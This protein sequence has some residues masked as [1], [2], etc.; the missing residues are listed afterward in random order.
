M[1]S[2]RVT[3]MTHRGAVRAGNE[4]ALVIGSLTACGVSMPDPI[5][6]ELALSSP[7]LVAVADGMGGH[8]GGAVASAHT[9]RSLAAAVPQDGADLTAALEQIDV[10]LHA[11]GEADP[12]VAGLGTTVAAVLLGQEGGVHVGIGDSRVYLVHGGYLAQVSTDH[13]GPGGGLTRCLGGRADG[14][15]LRATTETLT[16][17]DTLL[18]CSDGLSDLVSVETM[19][20]LLNGYGEPGRIVKSLWAAA[21]NGSGR[22]NITVALVE[23]G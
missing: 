10:D 2:L 8:A 23:R 20:E 22:D 15:A 12:G 11:M 14:S 16:E 7:V 17:A 18:L 3:A 13:R 5:T 9:A 1:T 6:C 19:E 4:D 21:M